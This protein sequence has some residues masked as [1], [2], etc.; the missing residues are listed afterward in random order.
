MEKRYGSGLCGVVAAAPQGRQKTR[1]PMLSSATSPDLWLSSSRLSHSCQAATPSPASHSWSRKEE[2]EGE[3]E[4]MMVPVSEKQNS[5]NSPADSLFKF[6]I[7]SRE[8]SQNVCSVINP[9]EL[10][11]FILFIYLF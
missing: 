1:L 2:E 3:E 5:R 4:E 8:V 9:A 10:K 6:G 7:L 11:V